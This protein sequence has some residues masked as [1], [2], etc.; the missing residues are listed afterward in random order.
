MLHHSLFF[1]TS[2]ILLAHCSDVGKIWFINDIHYQWTYKVGSDPKHHCNKGTGDAGPY[3]NFKCNTPLSLL[4]STLDFMN[5]VEPNPDY[6]AWL[7]DIVPHASVM[8]I[9]DMFDKKILKMLLQ[10]MTDT[11]NSRFSNTKKLW[12]LGNHDVYPSHQFSRLTRYVYDMVL[13]MWGNDIPHDQHDQFKKG[14]Y[15]VHDVNDKLSVIVLN[16]NHYFLMN[17]ESI[18]SHDPEH[19]FEWIEEQ[20]KRL[21]RED[22]KAILLFHVPPG[23]VE[24]TFAAVSNFHPQFNH[25]F[26][27]AL[28]LGLEQK[29]I[30]FAA[31]GHEHSQALRLL[32]DKNDIPTAPLFILPSVVSDDNMLYSG[33]FPGVRLVTFNRTNGN[34]L[35]YHQYYL[36]ITTANKE[37]KPNWQLHHSAR[38]AFGI[39]DV[40]GDSLFNLWKRMNND[41]ELLGKYIRMNTNGV[42]M[43][44][45]TKECAVRHLC[46]FRYS[47][48]TEFYKCWI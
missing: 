44:D 7:G 3:G 4:E 22:R 12:V 9:K 30:A 5:K 45:L 1:L 46:A 2:L 6:L 17:V 23:V 25:R 31:A 10:E 32:A 43:K 13:E 41:E 20:M 48:L 39:R 34:V 33:N 37:L 14:G 26:L 35:D 19:Q 38:E 27:D 36:N 47:R 42:A 21:E 11:I 29:R 15:Y 18:V 24:S 28:H 40:S 16:T 8:K